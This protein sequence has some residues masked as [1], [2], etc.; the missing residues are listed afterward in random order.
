MDTE[1]ETPQKPLPLARGTGVQDMYLTSINGNKDYA[2]G[3]GCLLLTGK[4]HARII[5]S[6]LDLLD[7]IFY[8][9]HLI[10]HD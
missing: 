7:C 2:S 3:N 9:K 1:F 8:T 4:T 10:N 5:D 6:C